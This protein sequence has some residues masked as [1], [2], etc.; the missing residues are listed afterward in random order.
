MNIRFDVVVLAGGF[1]TR[2]REVVPD[3]P[4]P[5]ASVNGVPF[6]EI[7]L[8]RIVPLKPQK[9]VLSVGYRWQTIS[10][11]FKDS[12]QGVPVEYSVESVPLGTGG[13]FFK[14]LRDKCQSSVILLL[15]GD[16]FFDVDC[17]DLLEKHILTKSDISLALAKVPHIARYGQVLFHPNSQRVYQ[18][19]EKNGSSESGC[20]NGG[21]YAVSST[22]LGLKMPEHFSWENDILKAKLN[23]LVV[24]GFEYDKT[25]IDIGI[26]ED[27]FKA[28]EILKA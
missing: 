12:F 24:S 10:E 7:L 18:F 19:I 2:L 9:I 11:Y 3:L 28:Q 26:P 5:M 27:Y 17:L 4:K 21:V 14:S 13:A 8:K 25:F 15:N 20:I 1:G 23:E 6:L 22:I 16:S